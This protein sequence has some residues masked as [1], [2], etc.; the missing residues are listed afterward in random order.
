MD[1]ATRQIYWNISHVWLMYVLLAPT[2]VVGAYGVYRR[3]GRWRQG[4]PLA[5]FD[6]PG[7]RFRLLLKEALGQSR[8]GCD[9]YVGLF[10]RFI[11][12]GFI[13]LVVATIIVA[14]DADLGTH[15]MHGGLYLYF[16]SFLVDLFG[17]LVL[18]GILLAAGRRFLTRPRKLV[19][20]AE[21]WWILAALFVIVLTGFLLEGWRIAATNDPWRA[22]SPCGNLAASIALPWMSAAALRQAHA[23]L[24]WFHLALSFTFLAWLPYTKMLHAITG[25]LNIFT[26]DLE[27][28][29]ANLKPVDFEQATS[30][31]VNSLPAFTWK[32][33]LDLDACTECGR[34]T[35]NCPA[36]AAGKELSPRDLILDLRTLLHGSPFAS[37]PL[38]G[39]APAALIG[40]KKALAAERLWQCTTCGACVEACPVFVEQ[41]PKIVD[42][43]RYLVMEQAELPEA[44][45]EALTSLESR[46][47]P[48]RGTQETRVSW[49]DGL[50]VSEAKDGGDFEVLLWV[51]CS[52][53]LMQRN[54]T[55]ARSTTQLLAAAGVKFAILGR[56]EKCCGD[57]AR[58]I[59]SEFLF[60]NLAKENVEILN[61]YGVKK[62]VTPCPH[63]FNT[64]RNEYPRLGGRFEVV[65]HSEFLAQLL[66]AGRLPPPRAS[67]AHAVAYHDPCYLGRQNG[68]YAAPRRVLRAAQS[69][70]PLEMQQRRESSFC[71]GGGGGMSFV[72]EPAGQRVNQVRARQVLA[73]GADTLAVACPF[74]LLMMEDGMAAR[75]GDRLVKV[76]DI[77]EILWNSVQET[78]AGVA[79]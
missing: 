54:Q 48:F 47:H 68:I 12:Y 46:S 8:A 32:D 72:E 59:G 17:A 78:V 19:Y 76:E 64:L 6:R 2:A 79:H 15:L 28:P 65:H 58:R 18:L 67:A 36:N 62:I 39:E 33:L 26:A 14:L 63:C 45:Q 3:V 43:R 30:L 10:H 42:L 52:A 55:I 4:L 50:H 49:A 20:S 11:L 61:R 27:R 51:G 69:A 34:C 22:W 5:R 9:A 66:E 21:S 56:E 29:G 73:T 24:W 53:A 44:M 25:P 41:M 31:G 57:P 60:E 75:Q 38:E 37:Q 35:E 16:Q 1:G 77:S 13:V 23:V 40:A 7:R 70:T 71:C 74:C